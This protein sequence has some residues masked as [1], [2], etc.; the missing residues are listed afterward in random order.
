VNDPPL[1]YKGHE[2]GYLVNVVLIRFHK[3]L[4]VMDT[5]I[6]YGVGEQGRRATMLE[7]TKEGGLTTLRDTAEKGASLLGVR[8]CQVYTRH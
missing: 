3:L 6:V 1:S 8:G 7:G 5:G 4:V 2:A